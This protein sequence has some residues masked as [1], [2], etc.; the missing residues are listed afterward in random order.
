[1]YKY[2]KYA[3]M[4]RIKRAD[5]FWL[6]SCQFNTVAAYDDYLSNCS[7]INNEYESIAHTRIDSIYDISP[8]V[9]RIK[10]DLIGQV[11]IGW[12]FDNLEEFLEAKILNELKGGGK[13]V[14]TTK[15]KLIDNNN[16]SEHDCEVLVE[17]TKSGQG[18]YLSGVKANYFTFKYTVST[19]AWLSVSPL[20]NCSYEIIDSGQK[21]WAKEDTYNATNY[22]GGPGGEVFHFSSSTIYLMSREDHPID[23]ILKYKPSE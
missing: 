8:D 21:Y 6:R 19:D 20:S 18:W 4:A 23:L 12:H 22:K 15:F 16:Q 1:M 17:Y 10:N 14:L 5:F 2:G 3:N 9:E 11:I 13:T 7:G